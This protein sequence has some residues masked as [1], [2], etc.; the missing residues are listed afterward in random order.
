MFLEKRLGC[1]GGAFPVRL[2]PLQ[3]IVDMILTRDL[4]SCNHIAK[5]IRIALSFLT[6]VWDLTYGLR[7]VLC[8]SGQTP[9]PATPGVWF[10]RGSQLWYQSR[11]I[12]IVKVHLFTPDHSVG[13]HLAEMYRTED[14]ALGRICK[15]SQPNHPRLSSKA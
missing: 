7:R 5:P 11:M 3:C 15:V 4:R 13:S 14:K 8:Q 12:A 9:G 10:L 1:F 6:S 2:L